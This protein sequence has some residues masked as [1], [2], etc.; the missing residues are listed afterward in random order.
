VADPLHAALVAADARRVAALALVEDGTCDV[1]SDAAV[2]ATQHGAGAIEARESLVMAGRDYADAV[3]TACGMPPIHWNV[4]DGDAV[5]AG[6][7]LG[8]MTGFLMAMLRAERPLLNLLQRSCGVATLT[9]RH[10]DAVKPHRCAV[11]H[12]RKTTPGLRLL[13][14]LSVLAGGGGL[15]RMDLSHQL[16]I[17]DNHWAALAQNGRSLADALAAARLHGVTDLYVEVESLEQLDAA[18]AAG[19]TRLLIDNQDPATIETWASR[20]RAI[21]PGIEIEATGGITLA[22]VARYAATGVDFVSIGALTHSVPSAN[23]AVEIGGLAIPTES[24]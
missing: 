4:M 10:V 21:T 9:R 16:L 6:S 1:T 3:V 5:T 14:V 20:A 12:T 7:V 19:A 13:E 11:L 23:I 2:I 22:T 18:C 24:V 17:K 15:Y 8:T